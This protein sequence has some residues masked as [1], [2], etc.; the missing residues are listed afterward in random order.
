MILPDPDGR[1]PLHYLAEDH[2]VGMMKLSTYDGA[3]VE[4]G[5]RTKRI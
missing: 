5:I 4:A 2:N 1:A 3:N